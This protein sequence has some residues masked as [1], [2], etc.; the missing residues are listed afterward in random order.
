MEK[1]E[2]TNLNSRQQENYNFYKVASTLADYGFNCLRLTDDYNGADFIALHSDGSHMMVQLKGRWTIDK[3]YMGK[4]IHICFTHEGKVYLYNHDDMVNEC[5]HSNK[6][7]LTDD[8]GTEY[9]L[10][11]STINLEKYINKE[12]IIS[13]F[14]LKYFVQSLALSGNKNL[15]N[16]NNLVITSIRSLML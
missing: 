3:K 8:D 11:T 7:V 15:S 6:Y 16:K 1:I 2:Y 4:N 13:G 5:M 12:V 9:A 14:V 10:S